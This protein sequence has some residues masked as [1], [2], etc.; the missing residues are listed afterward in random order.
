MD[1]SYTLIDT[2][3]IKT[4]WSQTISGEHTAHLSDAVL[5]STRLRR[6]EEAAAKANIEQALTQIAA[7]NLP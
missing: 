4:L 5:A 2:Q 7:L 1:V 3:A 6:T